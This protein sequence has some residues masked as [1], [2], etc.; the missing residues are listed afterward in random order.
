MNTEQTEQPLK[1]IKQ[2]ERQSPLLQ[3]LK[4]DEEKGKLLLSQLEQATE[5]YIKSL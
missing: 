5:N 2:N 1:A 3:L 4:Q